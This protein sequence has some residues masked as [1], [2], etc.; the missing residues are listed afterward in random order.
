MTTPSISLTPTQ[1][2]ARPRASAA[3]IFGMALLLATVPASAQ[4]VKLGAGV[5]NEGASRFEWGP[6]DVGRNFAQVG[7]DYPPQAGATGRL[8]C[9]TGRVERVGSE[10]RVFVTYDDTTASQVCES[11]Q[12]VLLGELPAGTYSLLTT[13]VRADGTGV[14]QIRSTFE[15]KARG[16]VCNLTPTVTLLELG[17]PGDPTEFIQRFNNDADLRHSLG[18]I[19]I[20][21]WRFNNGFSLISADYPPLADSQR[22][23]AALRGSGVFTYVRT[24]WNSE[25]LGICTPDIPRLAVEYY[26]SRFDRYFFTDEP[27]EI[28]KLD[29][30][31]TSGGWTRTG[32]TW[33]VINLPS[34]KEPIAGKVQQI[35]RFW[36][37]DVQGTP[38]HFFTADREE[39]AQLRDGKKTGWTYEGS[40]FWVSIPEAEACSVGFPLYRLYNNAKNG[41][42]SHRFAT[43]LPV[44]EAMIAQGWTKEGVTM[45]VASE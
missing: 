5:Y 42:P 9:G 16:A 30:A 18:D 8:V 41:A 19:S 37:A 14:Q 2:T 36:S 31:V 43:R 4:T 22:V 7:L 15:V 33:Q 13:L 28:A 39:C 11:L 10:F 21:S 1:P 44:V 24:F 6:Y 3:F 12:N 35:Y 29:N 34:A 17:Y 38:S 20:R 32:E 26:H 25:C 23:L 27:A 40:P 45:C